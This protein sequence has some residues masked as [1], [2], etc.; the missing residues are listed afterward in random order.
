MK[1]SLTIIICSLLALLSA[2]AEVVE[3]YDNLR[4]NS[5]SLYL[6][7]GGSFAQGEG[8]IENVAPDAYIFV[9]P[10]FGGGVTYN[11]RQWMRFNLAYEMSKYR[12]QQNLLDIQPDGLAYR[13]LEAMYHDVE[14]N[15]ETNFAEL[16]K[17]KNKQWN[18]YLGTGLGG[19]FA[20]GLDYQIRIQDPYV[21]P[22]L[23]D[24]NRFDSQITAEN[25]LRGLHALYFPVNLSVEYDIAPRFTIG[26]RGNLK[27]IINRQEYLPTFTESVGV[28]LRFNFVGRRHGYT[29]NKRHISNLN[30]QL[31]YQEDAINR[32]NSDLNARKRQT[33]DLA[34]EIDRLQK[35]LDDCNSRVVL[36]VVKEVRN[37]EFVVY[38]AH[39]SYD[40]DDAALDVIA[41]A[42]EYIDEEPN[43][44]A[45]I[46]AS[47]ST[48][49]TEQYNQKL[50]E[51]R[52][53]AVHQALLAAGV[54]EE[55]IGKINAIGSY[56]MDERDRSRRAII[57]VK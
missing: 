20:T 22:E 47:C 21:N 18:V 37:T 50:S 36:P 13:N 38:F 57:N 24:P 4:T 55:V 25:V 2:R 27:M 10:S 34:D 46:V 12:R 32:M 29:S 42:A 23:Y 3:S 45:T 39:D 14:L 49:G 8:L 6:L 28:V 51:R 17:R 5:W 30:G 15:F 56:G 7:G 31:D 26:V 35:D 33:R 43:A 52:A 53:N 11:P 40:L 1:K 9:C 41:E 48:I 54:P 16:F 44:T 19:M